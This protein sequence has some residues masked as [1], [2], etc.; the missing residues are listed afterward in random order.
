MASSSW[1]PTI[2]GYATR[3][4]PS[5]DSLLPTGEWCIPPPY[6]TY[7][8]QVVRLNDGV[9]LHYHEAGKYHW[10]YCT[11]CRK[12]WDEKHR[13]S[14]LHKKAVERHIELKGDADA[15]AGATGIQSLF[16][17]PRSAPPNPIPINISN[18]AA[19]GRPRPAGLVAPSPPQERVRT[20]N[21]EIFSDRVVE[22]S[23]SP[24]TR[25]VAPAG[26]ALAE[27]L[28]PP[29]YS[30]QHQSVGQAIPIDS[31]LYSERTPQKKPPPPAPPANARQ[32]ENVIEV[33]LQRKQSEDWGLTECPI[34]AHPANLNGPALWLRAWVYEGTR[35]LAV[36][37]Y[38]EESEQS[39]ELRKVELRELRVR[40]K[41]AV[42]SRV[43][44]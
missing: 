6:H 12:W 3:E 43:D 13:D 36:N 30:S 20:H 5:A 33:M 14:A 2:S 25:Q 31:E 21:R 28:F 16:Q 44:V 15:A 1:E 19:H 4:S 38:C 22:T 42:P 8:M 18:I 23:R 10:P 7:C 40:L 24:D 39:R 11:L 35:I 34:I 41:L 17:L 29:T 26:F 37:G 9:D 32:Y 27:T